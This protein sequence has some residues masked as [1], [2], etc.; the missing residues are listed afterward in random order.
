M[1]AVILA[2]AIP[3]GSVGEADAGEDVD[4]NTPGDWRTVGLL[5]GLFV[6]V[7]LLVNPL[8]WA[9]TGT[10]SSRARQRSWAAATT[11]ATSSSGR[12]SRSAASMRS[13]PGSGSRCPQAFWTGFCRW[14]TLDWL[15]QGFEQAA[16]PMNLLYAVIGVL[17]GTAVGV[18]PGI[19]PAMTVA[20]LL[21]V[22]Y[23][24]SPS[25]AFIMFAGIFYGGMYGGSTTSILLNTPGESS[26]VITAIE[27]NKMAKAGRAPRRRWQPRRSD[28]SS[29]APSAPRCWRRSHRRSRDSQ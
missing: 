19:G 4:P 16:T 24:V 18:L 20:L 1:L 5:V 25:A 13:T 2:I 22:T 28:H 6:A 8:G 17:L 12:C 27:G 10:C 21:P 7:I 9:I 15:L 11:S 14:K 26:S 3:R 29:R 23:N